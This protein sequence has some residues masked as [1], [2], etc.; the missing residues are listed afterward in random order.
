SLGSLW[1][2]PDFR[3]VWLGETV[4]QFGGQISLLALP[5]AAAVA[6]H[7]DATEM[8]LLAALGLLPYLVLGLPSGVWVDRTRRRPILIGG[9]LA[10]AAAFAVVPIAYV[11]GVLSMPILFAVALVTGS[12]GLIYDV[13]AQSYL[14]TLIDRSQLVEGNSKLQLSQSAA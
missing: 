3:R 13:A 4:S 11:L 6:L 1:H 9:A 5:L 14:P 7:A 8:G 10:M 2:H 12:G